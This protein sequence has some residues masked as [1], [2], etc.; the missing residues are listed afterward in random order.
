MNAIQEAMKAAQESASQMATSSENETSQDVA[1]RPAS[2]PASKP[3]LTTALA[4][5]GVSVNHWV[6][7]TEYGLFVG[8]DRIPVDSLKVAIDM[9]E[10]RGFYMKRMVRFGNPA[11]YISTYDGVTSMDGLPWEDV[12]A[13]AKT[14]DSNATT[15]DSADVSF[16]TLEDIKGKSGTIPKGSLL[17]HSFSKTNVK[18]F[19]AFVED[20]MGKGLLN[21]TVTAEITSE[22]VKYNGNEWGLMI[23]KHLE[24]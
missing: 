23:F 11:K 21:Q 2:I 8:K 3:S 1:I 20:I 19:L 12:V 24:E 14:I 18:E 7:V 15:Y 16:E 5:K 22:A 17:G 10:D 9:T 4:K 6:K 13:Q